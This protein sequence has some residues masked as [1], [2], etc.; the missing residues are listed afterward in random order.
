M[1][2]I[3]EMSNAE[4]RAALATDSKWRSVHW[5]ENGNLVGHLGLTLA[6]AIVPNWPGD[7][8]EAMK[9]E[10]SLVVRGLLAD[11]LRNLVE[12]TQADAASPEGIFAMVGASARQ[13]SE[14]AL[15]TI[16]AAACVQPR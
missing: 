9:I 13:R 3:S 4:L 14:A 12:V 1:K 8:A 16:R 6:P 15:A 10:R 2:Q 5:D 11:Y 7:I